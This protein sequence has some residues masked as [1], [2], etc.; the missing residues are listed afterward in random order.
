LISFAF[1]KLARILQM[2]QAALAD[3]VIARITNPYCPMEE[4][5]LL[6]F[7]LVG[8]VIFWG[9]FTTYRGQKHVDRK[10]RRSRPT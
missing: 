2:A 6:L 3:G 7:L 1:A 4:F 10:K 9:W 5:A 8:V